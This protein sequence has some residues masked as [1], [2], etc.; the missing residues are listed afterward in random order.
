[1]FRQRAKP[2]RRY[3]V[4][5]DSVLYID[6][7]KYYRIDDE[8]KDIDGVRCQIYRDAS[9]NDYYMKDGQIHGIYNEHLNLENL[10]SQRQIRTEEEKQGETKR[11]E[12]EKQG[13]TKRTKPPKMIN[14]L[15]TNSKGTSTP[16]KARRDATVDELI[17]LLT[18]IARD[19]DV[20]ASNSDIK[21]FLEE[22]GKRTIEVKRGT[23]LS[24]YAT[25]KK[26]RARIRLEL[27]TDLEK[28][29][30]QEAEV[31]QAE[32]VAT[33]EAEVR[34]AELEKTEKEIRRS[35]RRRKKQLRKKKKER[36]VERYVRQ[37]KREQSEQRKR[38]Q[39]EQRKRERM[40]EKETE[41]TADKAVKNAEER[42]AQDRQKAAIKHETA[43]DTGGFM[44][45]IFGWFVSGGG[46]GG[47]DSSDQYSSEDEETSDDEDDYYDNSTPKKTT[48][49][50]PR[51]QQKQQY[52]KKQ[53]RQQKKLEI[54]MNDRGGYT[55]KGRS[56]LYEPS[57]KQF[58]V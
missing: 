6:G 40:T 34:Q 56:K 44:H 48:T 9:G 47:N 18:S 5:D 39:G 14:I 24:D 58:T 21:I 12:K 50:K 35:E 27:Q 41:P 42:L 31:R 52:N 43:K 7:A 23:K 37:R 55:G 33:Q 15:V 38:E 30:K 20:S 28:V 46:G 54:N 51:K 8:F 3:D 11:P 1:M 17:G 22:K 57:F 49:R 25:L 32:K 2:Q 4:N 26:K 45:G 13:E 16:V 10:F 53:Q 19:A 36:F 29:A